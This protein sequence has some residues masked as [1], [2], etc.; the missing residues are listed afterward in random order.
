M[1]MPVCLF[2]LS[3]CLVC[4]SDN[5]NG[6]REYNFAHF[7]VTKSHYAICAHYYTQEPG[8][9]C[10]HV[11]QQYSISPSHC[12]HVYPKIYLQLF[13]QS[14][15]FQTFFTIGHCSKQYVPETQLQ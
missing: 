9:I 14:A 4:L 6:H 13:V 7:L 11:Y 2:G 15:P 8:W 5:N 10:L 1:V 3:V 12:E